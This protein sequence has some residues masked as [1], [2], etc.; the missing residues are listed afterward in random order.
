MKWVIMNMKGKTKKCS[1]GNKG[2]D[3][4]MLLNDT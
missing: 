2:G 1:F 4:R 3:E